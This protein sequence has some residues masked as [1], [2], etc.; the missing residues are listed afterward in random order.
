MGVACLKIEGRMK[1]PEYVSVVTGIYARALKEHRE[2]TREEVAQLEAAFSRQGFTQGYYRDQK[3]PAM[4]GTR[5]EG[6]KDPEDLFAQ[7]RQSYTRGEHRL[8]PVTLTAQVRRD[9]PLAVTASDDQGHTA[10]AQGDLPQ[11]ARS[12]DVTAEQI[13]GQLRKTGGTVYEA[14]SVSAQVESGLSVPMAAVNALRREVLGELDQLRTTPPARRVLPYH[15][16]GKGRGKP[17]RNPRY[18]LTFRRWEQVSE[19]ILAQRPALVFLPGEVWQDHG[20]EL[21]LLIKTYPD[22]DFG[23][24][25]PRVVWD[26]EKP[27]LERELAAAKEAG[28]TQALLGHIGLL[29]LCR[30]FDLV[31]RGDFGLGYLNGF[32]GAELARL[33]FRSAL[34]SFE[35]RF[36]QLRDV[37]KPLDTELLVYG[38]L[39]LM[40]TEN[41][42]LKNRG[43]GC[44]C[45][46]TPQS[47]RDRKG[48]DFPVEPAFGC[49]NELFNA[50]TLWL[51]DKQADWQGVGAA[52]ARLAFLRED[53]KTCA[54]V[55][56]AYR[57][58][59]GQGPADFTRGLYYRGVE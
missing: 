47:L 4:F 35:G 9:Q 6:T 8:S 15:G 58:G 38:R 10:A 14:A 19:D 30:D 57:E 46:E 23:V 42:I 45:Q 56:R 28:A 48:E 11:P 21:S 31:P 39:P 50:K 49:R 40:L 1:R 12:R 43:K 41:C 37:E 27:L 32:T 44:H 25:F 54:A 16:P 22:T 13:E 55:L 5:K 17:C 51:A 18:T 2:P 26:R 59:N 33:G 24:I 34:L 29:S 52:Y 3:G 53:A 36:S 7:A 20:R